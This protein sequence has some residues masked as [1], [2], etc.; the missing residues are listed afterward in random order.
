MEDKERKTPI[1]FGVK[2]SK[3]K[4]KLTC[5]QLGPL[6]LCQFSSYDLIIG[7][8]ERYST[9]LYDITLY[10]LVLVHVQGP[11]STE[12][13]F[14]RRFHISWHVPDLTAQNMHP[15]ALIV[16]QCMEKTQSYTAKVN[17]LPGP[18]YY[19][20][21]STPGIVAAFVI[22]CI[23]IMFWMTAENKICS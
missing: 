14:I 7:Q 2:R 22:I 5:P 11:Y 9:N 23:F 13:W 21:I 20:C 3:V 6:W 12:D 15:C 17:M 1:D 19:K 10:Q 8:I 18:L 4:V 16:L